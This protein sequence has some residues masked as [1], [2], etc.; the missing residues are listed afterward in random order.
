M[1]RVEVGESRSQYVAQWPFVQDVAKVLDE[2]GLS[3][4]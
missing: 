4:F 2:A 1:P 3:G